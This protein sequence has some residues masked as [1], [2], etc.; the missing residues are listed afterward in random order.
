MF[1]FVM[2]A[3]I[4]LSLITVGHLF[5]LISLGVTDYEF[6]FTIKE[7]HGVCPSTFSFYA[8]K[9]FFHY[10][11]DYSLPLLSAKETPAFLFYSI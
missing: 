3:V 6:N 10:I 9:T 1:N 7:N 5:K 11:K 2:C 4:G 8:N